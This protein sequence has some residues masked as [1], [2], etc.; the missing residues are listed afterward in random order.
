EPTATDPEIFYNDPDRDMASY[1]DSLGLPPNID[2]FLGEV[3]Q[4]SKGY[5]QSALTAAAAI[6]YIRT[7]FYKAGDVNLDGEVGIA[8]LI[9]VMS[10]F[11]KSGQAWNA[12]DFNGDG[13]I[14]ISDLID[15]TSNFNVLS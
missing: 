6:D 13:I 10:N 14:S 7:G 1:N 11:G 2:A 3:R 4:Q 5:W 8:D 15:L 12:G 9:I